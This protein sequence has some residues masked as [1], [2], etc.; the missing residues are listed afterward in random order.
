MAVVTMD[1]GDDGGG[2]D[3][4]DDGVAGVVGGG[5]VVV[6]GGKAEGPGGMRRQA[7]GKGEES[8]CRTHFPNPLVVV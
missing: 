1:G 5:W 4:G 3:D 8:P 2:G 7:C 6:V